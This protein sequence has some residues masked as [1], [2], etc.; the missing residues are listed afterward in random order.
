[1]SSPVLSAAVAKT[2]RELRLRYRADLAP[3]TIRS[4]PLQVLQ[5]TDLE[6]LLKGRDPFA[7]VENFPFWVKL[8]EAALV[9]ADLLAAQ[10]QDPPR[11]ILELGAGLGVPGLAAAAAG[12]QVTLSDYEPHILDFQR[13]SAAASGVGE[14]VEHLMLDWLKPPPDLP[15]FDLIIGAEILFRDEFFSPLLTIFKKYLAPGGM[16]YLAHDVRRKSL[17]RFLQLAEADFEIAVSTRRMRSDDAEFTIIV[18]RLQR[19]SSA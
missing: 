4:Y 3:L 10:P 7:E 16:V 1:M 18:N 13:V 2:L 5:V 15:P 14:R 6:P 11:R 19:R 9:L 17:P 12:H 8:W